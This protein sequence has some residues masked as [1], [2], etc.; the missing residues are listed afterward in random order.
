MGNAPTPG[1]PAYHM[2]IASSGIALGCLDV[3][4][5]HSGPLSSPPRTPV[6]AIA[7]TIV[8]IV[9]TYLCTLFR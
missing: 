2:F 1:P 8:V 3:E 5:S 6:S 9:A 4:P 7:V